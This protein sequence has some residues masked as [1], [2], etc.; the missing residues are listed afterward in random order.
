MNILISG[1]TGLLGS[2]LRPYLENKGH[3]VYILHRGR[4]SGRF[5]WQP[6]KNIIHIDEEIYLDAVINLNGVNI[7]DKPWSKQR[8]DDIIQSRVKCTQVLSKALIDRLQSPHT[9]INASAI[10]YY[11]DTGNDSVDEYSS[12]GGNFLTEIVTQWEAAAQPI[13]DSGIRTVFIRS[14]VI[15]TPQGGALKKMLLPFKLGLGGKVGNGQQH[16][17][18]I[19]LTDELRAIEFLLNQ[20]VISGPV[21]LTAPHPVTNSTFTKA[22]GKALKRPTMFPMPAFVVKMLFGEMG[23]LLLL[24]SNQVLPSVLIDNGFKFAYPDIQSALNAELKLA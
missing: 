16:M 19:S 15:L 7:A 13:I 22:L 8:K 4:S 18:W 5:Y 17:S 23:D 9:F 10:G 1:A 21:N 14:G 6:E 24:G 3:Q 12:A 11:G 2:A 20:S